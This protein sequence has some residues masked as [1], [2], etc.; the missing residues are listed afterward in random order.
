MNKMLILAL[1]AVQVVLFPSA[2]RAFEADMPGT[3][4]H[5]ELPRI[6]GTYIVGYE[7]SA[8]DAARFGK[9]DAE[10]TLATIT[11]EGK[12]TRIVYIGEGT[13]SSLQLFRNY[14]TAFGRMGEFT[15]IYSCQRA[16]CEDAR[17]GMEIVWTLDGK[18]PNQFSANHHYLNP[19]SHKNPMYLYGTVQKGETLYH[20]SVFT[21]GL[22]DSYTKQ[23]DNRPVAHIEILEVEEFEPSLQSVDADEVTS[24]LESQGHIALYGIQFDFDSATLQPASASTIGELA[25]S[26]RANADMSVYVVGHTDSEGD[27]SYNQELSQRRA[28]TV[29]RNLVDEYGIEADRLVPVGV[30]PVAPKANTESEDGR[31]INRRVEIVRR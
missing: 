5:P 22:L 7:Y 14:Q 24:R 28:A 31:A 27:Y 9:V 2:S 1:L 12:R 18:F 19:S 15:E 4:D 11:P 26:L 16:D 30:G 8:Y 20:V 23:A 29:A 3:K 13:Q 6:Q 17:I 10:K 21:A 25:N